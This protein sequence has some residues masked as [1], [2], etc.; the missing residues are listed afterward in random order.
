[1][2]PRD[3]VDAADWEFDFS[4]ERGEKES[5]ISFIVQ[6]ASGKF[7]CSCDTEDNALSV[8]GALNQAWMGHSLSAEDA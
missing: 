7:V 2:S 8:A 5:G 6:D 4:V 1:M 3:T